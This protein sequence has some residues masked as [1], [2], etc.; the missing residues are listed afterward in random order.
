[1]KSH[2]SRA[3]CRYWSTTLALVLSA[4][5]LSACSTMPD[6]VEIQCPSPPGQLLAEPLFLPPLPD[7]ELTQEEAVV[8]WLNDIQ[9]HRVLRD[10][11]AALIGW[12]Q[13]HCGWAR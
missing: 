4:A 6:V 3:A 5:S 10:R 8:A 11:H 7:R 13:A 12:G 2:C 9:A 1:M